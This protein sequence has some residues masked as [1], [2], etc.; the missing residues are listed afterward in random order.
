MQDRTRIILG[1]LADT[2]AVFCP[3]RSWK[4]PR[5][6]AIYEHRRDYP[7]GGVPWRSDALDEAGCKATQRDLEALCVEGMV[8]TFRP[9]RVKTLGVKLTAKGE[10]LAR[11]LCGLPNLVQAIGGVMHA[12]MHLEGPEA[13]VNWDGRFWIPETTLAGVD[14]V[15]CAADKDARHKLV[16]VEEIMLPA[17]IRGWIIANADIHGRV[18]YSPTP[19]GLAMI[20]AE[21][22]KPD[23]PDAPPAPPPA[24]F[25]EEAADY[26][27]ERFTETAGRFDTAAPQCEREIGEIPLPVSMPR[28]KAG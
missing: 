25:D 1:I 22:R 5:P 13:G 14:W 7:A 26:Y 24:A 16:F 18:W 9:K 17:L 12:T 11:A 19:E 10:A 8:K 4:R 21:R 23:P 3:N 6:T 2:D 15:K 20:E 27:L 28:R